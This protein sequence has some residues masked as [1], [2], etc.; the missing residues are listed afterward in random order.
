[1]GDH[2]RWRVE[3]HNE[4]RRILARYGIEAPSPEA[5]AL[6]GRRAAL[7]DHPSPRR[8]KRL[9]LLARAERRPVDDGSGWILYR[10]GADNGYPS[11]AVVPAQA[12]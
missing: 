9:S 11:P 5:A 7:A 12:P 4:Q 10:I 2:V 8:R 6:A 1:M 3:L